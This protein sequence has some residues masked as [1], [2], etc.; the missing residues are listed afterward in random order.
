MKIINKGL[1][2]R[3]VDNHADSL[4]AITRWMELIEQAKITN[5]NELKSVFPS[6]DYVGNSRYIFNIKGNSYRLVAVVLF[7]VDMLTICFVGTHSE[8][9]KV[10][11]LTVLQK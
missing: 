2:D 5:H 4:S 6:A 11:C 1:I 3:F 9:N 8:Y 7:T 10:N